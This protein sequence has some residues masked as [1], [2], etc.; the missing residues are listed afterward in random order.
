MR[1]HGATLNGLK[2]GKL[3][4]MF[5]RWG[6]VVRVHSFQPSKSCLKRDFLWTRITSVGSLLSEPDRAKALPALAK[7]ITLLCFLNASPHSFQP[8][9][10]TRMGAFLLEVAR[11]PPHPTFAPLTW[12]VLFIKQNI[13]VS[14]LER[15]VFVFRINSLELI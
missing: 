8:R 15:R 3:I 5:I 14:L 12:C 7:N 11:K 1:K 6:S 4:A 10:C 9:K 13:R 2:H